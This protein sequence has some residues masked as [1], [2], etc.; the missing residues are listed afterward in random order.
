MDPKSSD[1]FPF[2]GKAE[3]FETVRKE[4]ITTQSGECNVKTESKTGVTWPQ[5]MNSRIANRS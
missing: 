1:K 5:S 2:E 3:I 4:E